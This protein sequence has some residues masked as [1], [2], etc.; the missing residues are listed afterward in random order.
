[1]GW[2]TLHRRSDVLRRV[3]DEADRRRDG[4]LPVDVPGVRETFADELDLVSALHLRWHTRL[5]GR[6]EEALSDDPADLEASVLEGWRRAACELPGVRAILDTCTAA[7]ATEE[8]ARALRRA[9]DKEWVLL[10]AMAGRAGASDHRAATV[11][12]RIE[13]DA[14]S[15]CRPSAGLAV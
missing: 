11:G 6:I 7:P 4:V 3:V 8:M 10:A 14:R 2:Q 1:M 9:R 15:A 5:S 12:R 13:E